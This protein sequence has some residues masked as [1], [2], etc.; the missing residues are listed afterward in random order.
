MSGLEEIRADL[1]RVIAK[2]DRL[3]EQEEQ[4]PTWTDTGSGPGWPLGSGVIELPDD[5]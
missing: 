2:L 5:N 1:Q 4:P 3:L